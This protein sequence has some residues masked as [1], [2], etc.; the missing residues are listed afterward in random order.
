[1]I[2]ISINIDS[3]EADSDAMSSLDMLSDEGTEDEGIGRNVRKYPGK[4]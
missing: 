2:I 3:S 1:M 4:L